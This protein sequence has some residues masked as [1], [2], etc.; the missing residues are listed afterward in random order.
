MS[1]VD[2]RSKRLQVCGVEWAD[3][4]LHVQQRL[5]GASLGRYTRHAVHNGP[6]DT[7]QIKP[8][9]LLPSITVSCDR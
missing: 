6:H 9:H 3:M 5:Q 4:G 2:S 1:D 7:N 8:I